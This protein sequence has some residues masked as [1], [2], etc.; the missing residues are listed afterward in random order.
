MSENN[1]PRSRKRNISGEGN[2]IHTRPT[3]SRSD[4]QGN[5]SSGS[6]GSMLRTTGTLS[7]PAV[8]VMLVLY[9]L[10]GGNSSSTPT[11]SNEQSHAYQTYTTPVQTTS[12]LDTDVADGSRG[13]YTTILG[14]GQDTVT[15]MVYMCGSD[16]ESKNGMATRDLIEMTKATLSDNINLIVFTGGA[17]RWQNNVVSSSCNQIYQIVDGQMKTL[18]S[19]QGN[20]SMTDPSTLASYIQFC[21]KNFPANRYDLIFWDHGG[22]SVSGYG[23]DE[24]HRNK[25]SMGLSGINTALKQGGV[26]FDFIGFDACLMATTENALMLNPYAD[27]LIASEETEPGIGWYY[28]NWLTALSQNPSMPTI[29]IGKRIVDDFVSTCASDAYGQKATLSVVDLAELSNT[30][31]S[32]LTDFAKS[33]QRYMEKDGYQ[34]VSQA[35]SSTREFAQSSRID[36]VDLVHFAQNLGN[37]EGKDLAAAIRGA[38]KYN[39][40][41]SNMNN[42]NG[43]SIYF[44][45]RNTKYV[46]AMSQTYNVIDM[47]AEYTAC[48]REFASI[49]A[50]GQAAAS[51]TTSYNSL[52]SNYAGAYGSSS[53][54]S[55]SSEIVYQLLNAFL[56]GGRSMVE[57][58]DESNSSFVDEKGADYVR[59]HYF[60]PTYLGWSQDEK[61]SM[62]EEQW[63]M[64][65]GLELNLFYDDGNGYIDLGMDNVFDYDDDGNLIADQGDNW[66]SINNQPVAYYHL[67]TTEVGDTYTI[68]GRVPCMLNGVQA[69]LILV[70]D[71]DHEDGYIAGA[72]Y[73][74]AQD[75]AVETIAKN[76][77]E[78]NVGDTLDFL[79]THYAYDGSEQESYYLGDTMVVENNMTISNTYLNGT[80]VVTYRFTDMYNG[81]YWTEKIVRP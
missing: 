20:A 12:S 68:T 1:R 81:T 45:L 50:S 24:L 43:L 38:V 31:P 30:L 35:R 56:G 36:Q 78:L 57:G 18:V 64:V 22:G 51:T 46:D 33:I 54:S 27:Y 14:N 7:L 48:I 25:G 17:S 74:Y 13:K 72:V 32:E 80:T 2:G 75:D 21:A 9:F 34:T 58:L 59:N 15:L 8:I 60:D 66:I 65:T 73:D 55:Q 77:T 39:K 28:T 37:A 67:D 62:P 44:P 5:F 10:F 16:L 52:F 19:N 6:G 11:T 42:A 26:Q 40:T 49:S 71:T 3:S 61:I 53:S 23:Y 29:E 79:C 4:L 76:L 69:N 47:D 41:S 63:A 70:F